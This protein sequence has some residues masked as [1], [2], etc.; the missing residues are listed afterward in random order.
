[1]NQSFHL[2]QL[3]KVDTQLNRIQTRIDAIDGIIA[4]DTRIIAAEEKIRLARLDLDKT[5]KSLREL[6]EK[7]KTIRIEIEENETA[8]YSGKIRNPKELADLHAKVTA[9]KKV[10]DK[11]D[12]AQIEMMMEIERREA[13][14]NQL[15]A[16][17]QQIQ[18]EVATAHSQLLGEKSQLLAQK[19]TLTT[20]KS[21]KMASVDQESLEIYARLL[22]SKRGSAVAKVEERTCEAC[23]AP[24]TP[25]EWQTVRTAAGLVFCATCGR[26][27]YAN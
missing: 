2:Y 4:K 16:A 15:L 1:M 14:V 9:D 19:D 3:Q 18:T 5:R 17:L 25:S 27:L 26:I 22:K 7:G 13:N 10:L 8:M 11:N 23:G 12:D 6:E 21:A 20:E 24:L